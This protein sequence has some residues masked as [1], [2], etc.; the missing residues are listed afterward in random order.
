MPLFLFDIK[1]LIFSSDWNFFLSKL[2]DYLITIIVIFFL[3]ESQVCG[4]GCY[5]SSDQSFDCTLE[6]DTV[7][8]KGQGCCCHVYCDVAIY[9]TSPVDVCVCVCVG[10]AVIALWLTAKEWA[11]MKIGLFTSELS[12]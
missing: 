8:S 10:V 2:V 12:Y 3:S 9:Y 6:M 1:K 11:E 4:S 7:T 5:Y